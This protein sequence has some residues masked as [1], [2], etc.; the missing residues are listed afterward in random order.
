MLMYGDELRVQQG[1]DFNFDRLL[2]ASSTAYIPYIVSSKRLEG[3]REAYF[4]IT[5]ASTKFEKNLRYVCSFWNQINPT[6]KNLASQ[7]NVQGVNLPVFY[8]TVPHYMESINK[9]TLQQATPI[10]EERVSKGE[11]SYLYQWHDTD[12]NEYKYY[13]FDWSSGS[14]KRVDEYECRVRFNFTSNVTKDWTGQNYMY[15]VTLVSGQPMKDRL[16]AII[17]SH[18][19]TTKANEDYPR[20]KT[21]FEGKEIV[22]SDTLKKQYRYIKA[23]WAYEFQT[24]VDETSPLGTIETPEVILQPTKLEVFNNLR[25]LI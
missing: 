5:V 21:D 22:D 16:K 23:R 15:Q 10:E 14:A 25:K 4:V 24:D 9:G 3:G 1:E 19:G 20:F 2:S 11:K 12:A 6:G 13:W 7:E 8:Q 18:G 17:A